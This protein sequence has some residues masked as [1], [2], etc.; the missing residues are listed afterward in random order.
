MGVR[1]F[2]PPHPVQFPGSAIGHWLLKRIGWRVAFQGLPT[3]QGVLIVYPHTSNW[4]AVVVY[5][6]KWA[7]GLPLRYWAKAGLFKIPL[8]GAW[9]RS[10]GGIPIE[11]NSAR[12]MVG[13]TVA[14]MREAA[15]RGEYFWLALAPEGTR[16]YVDGWRSGFYR[17]AVQAGVPLGL[18]RL[19]YAQREVRVTDFLRLTGDESLDFTRIAA[20]LEG[21]VGR[22][23]ENAGPIRLSS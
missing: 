17:V 22:H 4:D 19:D 21:A 18:L 13:D 7:M 12:G 2:Q 5:I 15:E 8:F 23:P 11:R 14:Q 6:A 9:L 10:F 16:G 20:A 3:N 1:D